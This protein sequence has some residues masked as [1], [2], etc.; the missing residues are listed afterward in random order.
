MDLLEKLEIFV[1]RNSLWENIST[2]ETLINSYHSL[3]YNFF[4]GTLFS[5][6]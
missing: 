2:Y 1:Y 3:G 5:N 4:W 6:K